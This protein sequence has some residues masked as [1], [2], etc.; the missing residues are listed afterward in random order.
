MDTGLF[1][2]EQWTD[3]VF[4]PW[5]AGYC[6]RGGRIGLPIGKTVVY[7]SVWSR[8][9]RL[10]RAIRDRVNAGEVQARFSQPA[11]YAWRVQRQDEV[12][13]VVLSVLPFLTVWREAAYTAVDRFKRRRE[14]I[15]R[16][17]RR[18]REILIAWELGNKS[19]AE[20]AARLSTTPSVVAQII[21]RN[22]AEHGIA[23][24]RPRTRIR[25]T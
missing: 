13:R 3:A 25:R 11:S 24:R 17:E 10:I 12:E 19:Q 14:T 7:V 5:L 20:I 16:R 6:E 9:E 21:A 15:E 4:W 1:S 2:G 23:L 22:R 18:N 8:D